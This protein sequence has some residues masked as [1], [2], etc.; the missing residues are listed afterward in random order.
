[1][2]ARA[3]HAMST[4]ICVFTPVRR[5]RDAE[6]QQLVA[7]CAT[8]TSGLVRSASPHCP[9]RSVTCPQA[10]PNSGPAKDCHP[11]QAL[12]PRRRLGVG[13]GGMQCG[14]ACV[15]PR[16]A[17]GGRRSVTVGR[18]KYLPHQRDKRRYVECRLEIQVRGL[19]RL[20]IGTLGV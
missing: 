11:Q 2:T 16:P 20:E 12:L 9:Q 4:V 19:C 18:R 3:R 6:S 13:G 14:G 8:H 17:T 5:R 7:R 15:E 1:V 10:T